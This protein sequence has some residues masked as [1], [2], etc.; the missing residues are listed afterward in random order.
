MNSVFDLA[1]PKL[2]VAGSNPVS[3]FFITRSRAFSQGLAHLGHCGWYSS[4]VYG[5]PHA[6]RTASQSRPQDGL[7]DR[8][9][10]WEGEALAEPAVRQGPHPPAPRIALGHLATAGLQTIYEIFSQISI[11]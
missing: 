10:R 5:G 3:R 4:V 1:I 11:Q 8:T 7:I 2:N 9:Q 6:V